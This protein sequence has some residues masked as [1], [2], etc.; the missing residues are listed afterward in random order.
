MKYE[1]II[2]QEYQI[3]LTGEEDT[4]TPRWLIHILLSCIN[5]LISVS[6]RLSIGRREGAG[7]AY[8][9]IVCERHALSIYGSR[10]QLVSR[11]GASVKS[12]WLMPNRGFY[13]LT[14]AIV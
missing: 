6:A 1:R 5:L 7:K 3:I 8:M 10:S 9:V 4:Y 11:C 13:L 2:E 14:I 12:W